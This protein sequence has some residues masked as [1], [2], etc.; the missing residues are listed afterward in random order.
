M[1]WIIIIIGIVV[2]IYLFSGST[3]NKNPYESE[4]SQVNV[5]TSSPITQT[6]KEDC[7]FPNDPY[8]EG[9]GHYAGFEWEAENGYEC[10]GNSDSFIEGCQEYLRQLNSYNT[11]MEQNR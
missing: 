4:T 1:K 7:Q 5:I 10:G 3:K 11:C 2:L 6:K 8:D 9:S